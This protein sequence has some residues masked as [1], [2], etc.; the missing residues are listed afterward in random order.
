MVARYK[1][2]V[3]A[4]NRMYVGNIHQNGKAYGDR[5]IKSPINKYNILPD[6]NF[7]DVAINDG[8]EIT[9][10]AYYKDKLLQFKK[11]KVFVVNTSGDY[12]FLEDTFQEI[13][14]NHQCQVTTTPYGIC[15]ANEQG[16][17]L[18]NGERVVNL[19][20]GKI[21]PTSDAAIISNNYWLIDDDD[22][23]M[24]G[25][26]RDE[27]TLLVLINANSRAHGAPEGFQFS[28]VT[29]SWTFIQARTPD[30]GAT[31]NTGNKS[32]MQ[33]DKDGKLIWN[34]KY[35]GTTTNKLVYWSDGARNNSDTPG[36]DDSALYFKSK[37]FDFGNPGVRKK[38]YKVYVTYKS[39]DPG[40]SAA[41]SKILVKHST[42]GGTSYTAFSDN[43]T[44]YAA[45]TGLTGST[46]WA[47]AILKPTSSINNIYSFQL[48]FSAAADVP[49]GFEINDISIVY[50]IKPIK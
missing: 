3:V 48:E 1:T 15:W 35:Q 41:D 42:N 40:G 36:N 11:K 12:E 14:V 49:S 16:C 7:I 32:N 13:G 6:V 27:K 46:S 47:T 28:F 8:D 44:N 25:Y 19:I 17:H 39:V 22:V 38:I 4:N 21:A 29:Q 33:I 18:Y 50:R 26:L 43:S 31:L 10:L 30:S 24:V 23:S 20:D 5:M 34:V 2:T 9:A 37:D 45:S